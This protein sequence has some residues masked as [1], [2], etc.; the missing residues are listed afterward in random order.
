MKVVAMVGGDVVVVV[1][2]CV[3]SH[4]F[5]V[6]ALQKYKGDYQFLYF[7]FEIRTN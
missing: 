1:V 2:V 4:L 6:R 7:Y 3:R 5:V